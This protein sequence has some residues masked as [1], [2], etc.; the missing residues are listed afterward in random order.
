M[1]IIEIVVGISL[2]VMMMTVWINDK[3]LEAKREKESKQTGAIVLQQ[4]SSMP[5]IETKDL[6]L[7]TLTN[8]G[9]Q[10]QIR[11]GNEN[12]ILFDYQ[13]EHFFAD[14]FIGKQYV[15]FCDPYWEHVELYDIDEV[16]RMRKAINKANHYTTVTTIY[17]IDEV[18][19]NFDVH[20]K[21]MLPFM[22]TIPDLEDYL[23]IILSTFFEAHKV[24]QTEMHR[25]REQER[26]V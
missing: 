19:K 9:C 12:R 15:Q 3:K 4:P 14:T 22:S 7:K 23:K 11:E 20:S 13:G 25:L 8:I 21:T 10:Y 6:L 26:S 2:L 1:E 24:V 5:S 17:V 16:S 18:G